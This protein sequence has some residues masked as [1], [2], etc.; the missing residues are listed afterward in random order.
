MTFLYALV[1]I[2]LILAKNRQLRNFSLDP[3]R[4]KLKK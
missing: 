3:A 1:T 4:L 2:L